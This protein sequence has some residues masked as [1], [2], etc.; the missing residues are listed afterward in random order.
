M[1]L[2]SRIAST[3]ILGAA[4]FLGLKPH[5]DFPPVPPQHTLS[6]PPV[7]IILLPPIGKPSLPVFE[8]LILEHY[9]DL[10]DY[11]SLVSLKIGV[12][13]GYAI[14]PEALVSGFA[15][16][17]SEWLA[18]DS[19]LG[20]DSFSVLWGGIQGGVPLSLSE[21]LHRLETLATEDLSQRWDARTEWKE[22]NSLLYSS[23]GEILSWPHGTVIISH[24][25]LPSQEFDKGWSQ[26]SLGERSLSSPWV[27]AEEWVG[28][29]SWELLSLLPE[30]AR[31][32]PLVLYFDE[33]SVL[34]W[35]SGLPPETAHS[36]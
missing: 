33:G 24:P 19:S 34:W 3:L 27:V 14:S 36:E 35:T 32:L 7:A 6:P 15:L 12:P 30:E 20:T 28:W 5:P 23:Q 29:T 21:A 26:V 22:F 8:E 10:S 9:S 31:H 25:L 1:T 18:V 4:L 13:T 2:F 11:R 17:P 16:E